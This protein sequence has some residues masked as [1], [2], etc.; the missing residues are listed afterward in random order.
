VKAAV[1]GRYTFAKN[2]VRRALGKSIRENG[3]RYA[4]A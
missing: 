4:P 2:A 1:L 3:Q